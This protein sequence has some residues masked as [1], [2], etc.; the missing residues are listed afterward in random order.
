MNFL[1]GVATSSYQIEGDSSARGRANWDSFA[2]R[3]GA[4]Y[5]GHDAWVAAD[6]VGHLRED[7]DLLAQLGVTAYRFSFSWPRVLPEG[8]GPL[9]DAGLRF[10]DELIDGLLERGIEP[11]ATLFHWD[12]PEALEREGGFLNAAMPDWFAAYTEVLALRYGDRVRR[13]ITLNEPH[14][15]IEGGLRQGRHAPGHQLPI[16]MVLRAAHHALL[17]HGRAVDV[18]RARV[19]RSWITAAPVL[20]SAVPATS[21]AADVEAARE[22]TWSQGESLRCSAFWMDPLYAGHYADSTLERFGR[23]LPQFSSSDLE[24][25]GR[26]L[27]AVGFNLYDAIVARRAEDGSV[28]T[29]PWP[30]G[31]P[32]TAFDWPITPEAHYYGPRFCFERYRRPVLIAENGLSTRDWVALDGRVHD[33]DR[34]D[35]LERH[36]RELLR[37]KSQGVPIEGYFHWSFLDNF[38]WNHGYRERFGLVFVDYATQKRTPKESFYRYHSLIERYRRLA[39]QS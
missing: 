26:P 20:I 37:A 25:I 36:V 1:W 10:Y 22:A 31:A 13:F 3:P 24:Q 18:L 33:E 39:Q 32:R 6:H 11:L 9:N 23:H 7:L 38:E 8:R 16:S 29:V 21:D 15:F 34:V 4:I 14:A 17:S 2:E 19:A 30:P 28:Q 27:D 35:F 5:R 12:L